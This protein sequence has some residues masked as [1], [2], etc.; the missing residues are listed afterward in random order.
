MADLP[1]IEVEVLEQLAAKQRDER[2]LERYPYPE[3]LLETEDG[4]PF[5]LQVEGNDGETKY[6]AV[7]A[8]I[9]RQNSDFVLLDYNDIDQWRQNLWQTPNEFVNTGEVVYQNTD[10]G[11]RI[12]EDQVQEVYVKIQQDGSAVIV[13]SSKAMH[14]YWEGDP[15]DPSDDAYMDPNTVNAANALEDGIKQAEEAGNDVTANALKET[16]GSL[17][18]GER[19]RV[20]SAL[21]KAGE[22]VDISEGMV[23]QKDQLL[24]GYERVP[25][26][27]QTNAA[28]QPSQQDSDYMTNEARDAHLVLRTMTKQGV[29][30]PSALMSSDYVMTEARISFEGGPP[31]EFNPAAEQTSDAERYPGRPIQQTTPQ[32][33]QTLEERTAGGQNYQANISEFQQN[34]LDRLKVQLAAIPEGHPA[35]AGFE[36]QLDKLKDQLGIVDPVTENDVQPEQEAVQPEVSLED[37]L[38]LERAKLQQEHGVNSEGVWVQPDEPE[39]EDPRQKMI[40]AEQFAAG[41]NDAIALTKAQLEQQLAADPNAANADQIR[42][43]LAQDW[44]RVSPDQMA[45]YQQLAQQNL[46]PDAARLQQAVNSGNFDNVIQELQPHMNKIDVNAAFTQAVGEQLSD[47]RLGL[48]AEQKQ[49]VQQAII[50]QYQACQVLDQ[51]ADGRT[52]EQLVKDV[53][54]TTQH[55]GHHVDV[56]QFTE[57]QMAAVQE[58]VSYIMTELAPE[59]IQAEVDKAKAVADERCATNPALANTPYCQNPD[60]FGGFKIPD[61]N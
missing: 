41:M 28:T 14:D 34:Q 36:K 23:L 19:R 2:Q 48:N 25:V 47:P 44:G 5:V 4:K 26:M 17:G 9:E 49:Q 52:K 58:R 29:G 55:L 53:C 27:E 35:R 43:A 57:Q 8:D 46:P 33:R 37:R 21:V 15:N 54:D 56:D 1:P 3:F 39:V 61:Q 42:E 40:S 24:I 22:G 38:A 11:V 18:D 45:Q 30:E 50:E 13:D 10:T 6:F 31:V 32:R 12:P 59:G 7:T 16:L 20:Q 60:A 51:I